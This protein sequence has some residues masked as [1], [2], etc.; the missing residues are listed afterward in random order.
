MMFVMVSDVAAIVG[1]VSHV[2]VD[3]QVRLPFIP[4][5]K[6]R[7]RLGSVGLHVVA[8]KVLISAGSAP[9]HLSWTI[10]IDAI[11]GAGS[12]V[13]V[14]V[15]DRNKKQDDVVQY[16]G[17]SLRDRDI[18][19]ERETGVFAIRLARVNAG[20]DQNYGFLLRA[21]GFRCEDTGFRRDQ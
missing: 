2:T 10:L 13:T 15:V 21:C 11:V 6:P 19:Q 3:E 17:G 1:A 20:L 18:A 14:G 8:V 5:T 16:A 7:T 4:E 9:A 12:F